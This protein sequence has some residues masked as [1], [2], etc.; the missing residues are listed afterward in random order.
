VEAAFGEP[1]AMRNGLGVAIEPRPE[2]WERERAAHEAI[3]MPPVLVRFYHHEPRRW[4]FLCDVIADMHSRSVPVA[5]ALVQDRVSIREPARWKSFAARVFDGVGEKADFFEIGHAVNRVKWGIWN[6]REYHNM[7]EAT[8][9]A[10]GGRSLRLTGPAGID[11]EYPFVMA[12]LREVPAGMRFHALSHHLY[13]DRR[14][15]PE[16]R[17]G[18]FSLLEKLAMARAMA[19][20]SGACEDRLFV[21]E[22]NWPLA[23][24]G[25][26]SPVGSPYESPG[27]RYNDPSVSEDDYADFML[28]YVLIALASG[29]AERVYWWRLVARGYGLVDDTDPTRWRERPAFHAAARY[30]ATL[31]DARF[32]RRVSGPGPAYWFLFLRPSGEKVVA[33]YAHPGECLCRPPF[34]YAEATDSMGRPVEARD[35]ALRLGGRLIYLRAVADVNSSGGTAAG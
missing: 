29:L 5:V 31:G 33:G 19:A 3:G 17:Q 13:V 35:G 15:A 12:A 7:L 26:Y 1:V 18:R 20:V 2:T 21:S 22:V 23:G 11:F 32:V 9:D 30:F 28:R 14:G 24:T 10:L 4:D 25:V 8:A 16:N 27:V 34:G 6:Y